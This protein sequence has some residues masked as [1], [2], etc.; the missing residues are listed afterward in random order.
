MSKNSLISVVIFITAAA[1]S[2]LLTRSGCNSSQMPDDNPSEE[3]EHHE[4]SAVEGVD[5]LLLEAA[6]A[7]QTPGGIMEA[8]T[9]Y[10]KVL[11]IDSN[12]L[13]AIYSLG[14]L[15]IQSNQLQKAKD[16]FKKLIL[17]QP[18][19]QEYKKVYDQILVDLGEQ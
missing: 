17:L 9:K 13:E 2:F 18:Q 19:N 14:I 6:E 12:N 4:E 11:E 10:K 16:R 7:V 5:Q 15:S 3:V 1:L 8:V